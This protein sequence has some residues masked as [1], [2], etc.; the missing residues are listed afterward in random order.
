MGYR[1]VENWPVQ[2]ALRVAPVDRSVQSPFADARMGDEVIY[3]SGEGVPLQRLSVITVTPVV[4][5]LRDDRW[6]TGK[7][8]WAAGRE[9]MRA[10]ATT[11][12]DLYGE[13]SSEAYRDTVTIGGKQ[14]GCR[15]F[16]RPD[17]VGKAKWWI[18]PGVV[19]VEGLVKVEKDGK[20]IQLLREFKRGG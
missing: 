7:K 8:E 10:N 16:F 4:A 12:I 9:Y 13:E 11:V 14:I 3:D 2:T 20:V 1:C 5:V 17:R 6:D 19:P 18:A 15:T